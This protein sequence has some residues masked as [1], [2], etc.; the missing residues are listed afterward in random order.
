MAKAPAGLSSARVI[1][2][3]GKALFASDAQGGR[4]ERAADW[5]AC[6]A[7]GPANTLMAAAASAPQHHETSLDLTLSPPAPCVLASPRRLRHC[8]PERSL[9]S[10]LQSKAAR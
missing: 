3:S 9:T 8:L 1:L 6:A 4:V 7:A 10:Q 2:A 5:L